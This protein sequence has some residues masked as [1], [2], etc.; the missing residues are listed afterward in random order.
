MFYDFTNLVLF[1]GFVGSGKWYWMDGNGRL[2]LKE[3]KVIYFRYPCRRLV[4]GFWFVNME[5]KN[6]YGKYGDGIDEVML[7]VSI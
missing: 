7:H 4:R 5:Y 3:R 1:S 6:G 2:R